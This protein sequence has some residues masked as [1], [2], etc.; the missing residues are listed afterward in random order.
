M[1]L[2]RIEG[3]EVAEIADRTARSRRS[4]ERV[5]QEFRRRLAAEL[6]PDG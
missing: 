5:L 6:S 2:L 1:V 3:Y 4:V